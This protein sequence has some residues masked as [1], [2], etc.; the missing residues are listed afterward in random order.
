MFFWEASGLLDF[1]LETVFMKYREIW[2]VT[3]IFHI[4]NLKGLI[5]NEGFHMLIPLALSIPEE[6]QSCQ[7]KTEFY[8]HKPT[9]LTPRRKKYVVSEKCPGRVIK[10]KESSNRATEGKS[11]NSDQRTVNDIPS[12]FS[13]RENDISAKFDTPEGIKKVSGVSK[14]IEGFVSDLNLSIPNRSEQ[15]HLKTLVYCR[16]HNRSRVVIS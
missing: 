3:T 15:K 1:V 4:W 5:T 13:T 11:P 2:S 8:V 16:C 14:Q 6:E 12:V 10:V 7:D 9:V